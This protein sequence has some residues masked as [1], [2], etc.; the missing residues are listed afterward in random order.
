MKRLAQHKNL[1]QT[2]DPLLPRVLS[3]QVELK[4]EAA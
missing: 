4:T 3:G 2:H 1:R